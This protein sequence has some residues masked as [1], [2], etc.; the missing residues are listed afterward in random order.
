VDLTPQLTTIETPER[1]W[2]QAEAEILL[3]VIDLTHD[4]IMLLLDKIMAP[5][6]RATIAEAVY[7]IDS[8][9]D[10]DSEEASFRDWVSRLP[11]LLSLRSNATLDQLAP[12][13]KWASQARWRY[14]DQLEA[15]L[16]PGG[17]DLPLWVNYIY[18]IGRYLVATK[19]MLKLATKHPDFFTSIRV[20]AVDAPERRAFSLGNDKTALQNT[21]SRLAEDKDPKAFMHRLREFWLTD[22]PESRLRKA[23]R[24]NLNVHAEMQL[25]AFYDHYPDLTPRLLYIGL[26]KKACYLCHE[27]MSRHPLAMS[28]GAC[29]QKLYPSW[30][31]APCS[32]KVRRT[33]KPLLWNLTQHLEKTIVRDL[34]SRLGTRRLPQLD[35]TAGPSLTTTDSRFTTAFAALEIRLRDQARAS[36]EIQET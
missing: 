27:F 33:H 2:P 23:C 7:T 1:T 21:L 17:E 18:K 35:S 32:S 24:L 16:C 6:V 11:A 20:E 12:H 26:S 36:E 3:K 8:S 31:P 13:V 25:L 9:P 28:V 30:M 14:A 4:K 34:K 22:D 15:L 10:D 29:H 19:A 5:D